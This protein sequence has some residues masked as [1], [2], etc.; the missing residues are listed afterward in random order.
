L[1]GKLELNEGLEA[2]LVI[3]TQTQLDASSLDRSINQAQKNLGR[4]MLLVLFGLDWILDK[5]TTTSD[6]TAVTVKL[7]L[8]KRD[9]QELKHM[10]Q[11]INKMRNLTD[12]QRAA[13]PVDSGATDDPDGT[14]GEA[15]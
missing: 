15:E 9:L 8:D 6:R 5:I 2:A 12:G 14:A 1:D 7:M 11:R 3:A 4:N 13:P 10:A